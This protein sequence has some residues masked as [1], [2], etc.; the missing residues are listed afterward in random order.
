MRL[1]VLAVVVCLLLIAAVGYLMRTRRL[2]EKY[3]AVWIVLTVAVLVVGLFPRVSFWLA[4]LVGVQTPANLLFATAIV[5]LLGVCIQLSIEVSSLEEETRTLAEEVALLRLD[6]E[7]LAHRNEP[8]V[9]RADEA[10]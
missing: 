4:D 8:T 3:A 1:Y 2:R 10:S 9:T 6:V 5:V 7:R